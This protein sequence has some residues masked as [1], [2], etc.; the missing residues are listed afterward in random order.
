MILIKEFKDSKQRIRVESIGKHTEAHDIP[1]GIVAYSFVIRYYKL[2]LFILVVNVCMSV[3]LFVCGSSLYKCSYAVIFPFSVSCSSA[4]FL[5]L[6]PSLGV[7]DGISYYYR[8]PRA[9]RNF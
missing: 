4:Y 6:T 1:Y 8:L 7:Y 5:S 2:R 3:C 9:V